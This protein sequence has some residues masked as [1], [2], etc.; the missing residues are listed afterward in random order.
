MTDRI[1]GQRLTRWA[2]TAITVAIVVLCFA[3]SL[4][5]VHALAYSLGAAGYLP[6]VT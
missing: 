6:C 3:F 1:P 2:V 4:G 5:N